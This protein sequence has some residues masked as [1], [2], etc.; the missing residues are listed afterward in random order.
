VLRVEHLKI[1]NLPPL[2]FAVA[3]GECLAI[4]G[5]S[6]SGKTRLLRAIADLDPAT[7]QVFCDGLER[8]EMAATAWRK[9]VR[10]VAAEPG[11]WTE[12]PREALAAADIQPARMDRL[13]SSVGL[14][15]AIL[16]RPLSALSTGERLR[17]SLVRALAGEP[18]ALLL[19]EPTAA[20][21]GAATALVGELIRFH[22]LAGRSVLLASH[23][24]EFVARLADARLQLARPESP[25]L[26]T[27]AAAP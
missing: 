5:P 6:G 13:L 16:D 7:G 17:I 10:F 9:L 18:R 15:T 2:S 4:E 24:T 1:G 20:L 19:D 27:P 14:E 25:R 22:I 23:D 11:W 12:T 3:G 8:S 21:D 26:A